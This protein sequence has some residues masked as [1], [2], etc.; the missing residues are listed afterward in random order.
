MKRSPLKRK[1]PLRSTGFLQKKEKRSL[2]PSLLKKG[3]GKSLSSP[4]PQE[5]RKKLLRKCRI[6]AQSKKREKLDR[7]YSE[8]RK[9]FLEKHPMCMIY[10]NLRADHIH[11]TRHRGKYYLDE[12]TWMAVSFRAHEEIHRNVSW[13]RA[14]GYLLYGGG[15]A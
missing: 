5:P 13:A 7:I 4:S 14:R 2:S 12:S 9:A 11:H 8:K 3:A 6:R 1:T 15:I 10:P